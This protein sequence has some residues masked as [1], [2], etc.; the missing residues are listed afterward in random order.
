MKLQ[1]DYKIMWKKI[2]RYVL[3]LIKINYQAY[4]KKENKAEELLQHGDV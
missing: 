1:E 3:K 4:L 2:I